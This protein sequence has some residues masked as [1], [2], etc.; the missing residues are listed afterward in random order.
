M[1]DK[2]VVNLNDYST[3]SVRCPG[4]G[5]K[6]QLRLRYDHSALAQKENGEILIHCNECAKTKRLGKE[7][8]GVK[9][10]DDGK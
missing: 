10:V 7:N 1:D 8:L 5:R 6:Y 2:F 4:C 3:F 9:A